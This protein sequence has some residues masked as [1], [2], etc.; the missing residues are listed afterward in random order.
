MKIVIVIPY[1]K[2]IGG[3]ARYAWELSEYLASLGDQVILVSLYTDRNLYSTKEKIRIIDLADKNT[4]TQ[5]IKFWFSL[6][7]IS[8]KLADLIKKENADVVFFNHYPCTMWVQKYDSIPTLCYPQD[9][10]LLYT[11]TYINN[12]PF[13]IRLPWRIIR[14]FV[15]FYDKR[16]SRQ[17]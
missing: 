11:N 8:K 13:S 4:L 14:F 1:L 5:S 15:R 3:A 17:N 10:N 2:S 9:I 6:R 12:L 16:K 7:K